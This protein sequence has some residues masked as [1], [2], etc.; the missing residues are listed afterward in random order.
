MQLKKSEKRM[1]IF[2]GV[3][4]VAGIIMQV[5]NKKEPSRR[6][7]SNSKVLSVGK[8]GD[9]E[10]ERS[11]EKKLTK[12]EYESWG[13]NP[14]ESRAW[15]KEKI[16]DEYAEMKASLNLKGILWKQGK[17]YALI[18]DHILAEGETE[19]GIRVISITNNTVICQAHGRT[20]TLE[21]KG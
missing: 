4:V 19:E 8:K 10:A 21:W 12:T 14:F 20:F 13:R 11:V 7:S 18:N 6:S 16:F 9:D 15:Q 2:L 17:P 5:T 3:V 1:L